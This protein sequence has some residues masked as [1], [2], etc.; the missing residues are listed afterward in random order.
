M[1][2]TILWPT[3]L[4]I[5]QCLAI[6]L[7]VLVAVAWL[8]WA[9]RKVL[10][11]IRMRQGPSV[12][13]PF[14]LLQPVADG[15]KLLGKEMIVP[16]GA[17]RMLFIGAPILTFTLS[18]VAWAVIPFDSGWVLAADI[19]VALLYVL[20]ILSLGVY[21]AILSGWAS[22]SKYAFLNGMRQATQMIVYEIS[23]G[24]VIVAVLLTAGSLDLS[25]IVM[26]PMPWWLWLLLTPMMAVFFVS[27]LAVTNRSPF[28]LSED[29]S[30]LAGGIHV[31]YSAMPLAL[32]LIGKYANMMLMSALMVVL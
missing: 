16:D 30:E 7:P 1:T 23:I 20:A 3:I 11:A 9:E 17:D 4:L 14:G 28:D 24:L 31:E 21:G 27:I 13:G 26:A 5:L 2:G 10:G 18:L 22:N 32:F 19:N 29:G 15:F 25:D 12:A 6:I 8:T